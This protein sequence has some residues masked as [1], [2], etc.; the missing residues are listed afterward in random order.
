[1]R[2][3]TANLRFPNT[4]PLNLCNVTTWVAVTACL[5]LSPWA[6]EFAYFAGFSGAGMALLTPN[7]GSPPAAF[8]LN[9]G[10]IILTAS[11]LVYGRIAN[12]RRGAVWRAYASL[13]LYMALI[14]FFDWKYHVNYSFLCEKPA[15]TSLLTFLG[16]WPYYLVGAGVVGLALFW[17]LSLPVGPRIPA[18]KLKPSLYPAQ[19]VHR[20]LADQ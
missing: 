9:H 2:Y 18:N 15:S 10:A 8:F 5:T 6:V 12:L 11:A 3:Q 14:G 1:V 16:P 17:L 19:N 13:L 20:L 4:L 7:S